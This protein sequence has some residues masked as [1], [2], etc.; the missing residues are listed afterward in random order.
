MR[1][2]NLRFPKHLGRPKDDI[3]LTR[4]QYKWCLS[5]A[6]RIEML[7]RNAPTFTS[8]DLETIEAVSTNHP[9]RIIHPCMM[10][11]FFDA[12][13]LS[14]E[15]PYAVDTYKENSKR[16][17]LVAGDSHAEF[18]SRIPW[19]KKIDC[20]LECL[21][22]GA[23][24]C[25]GFATDRTSITKIASTIQELDKESKNKYT[26]ILSFG[27]IDVRHLFYSMIKIRKLFDHPQAYTDFIRPELKKRIT[28][29]KEQ[30]GITK[31]CILQPT[32]T[33]GQRLAGNP[34]TMKELKDYYIKM[35]SHPV[36]GKPSVRIEYWK[37]MNRFLQ[38]F[39]R[40][41]E[42]N[43]ILRDDDAFEDIQT[44]SPKHTHDGCHASSRK[45][46]Y[47]QHTKLQSLGNSDIRVG[48]ISK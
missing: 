43:Y 9:K 37:E 47:D 30:V 17:I 27:E 45:M 42:L 6:N 28:E 44:L 5:Y 40:N 21:W 26:L 46:L 33:T 22:T 39:C 25:L 16:H 4:E 41:N 11:K 10:S 34:K 36:L 24:T 20:S 29:L 23:T 15:Y 3:K 48:S 32:P 12:T 8:T 18:F 38:E 35:G 14:T 31:L 2:F 19:D 1:K 7:S 13:N